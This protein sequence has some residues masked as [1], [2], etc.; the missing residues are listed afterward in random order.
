MPWRQ[1]G[2]S[3]LQTVAIYDDIGGTSGRFTHRRV[4][5]TRQTAKP[6]VTP[7]PAWGT[8][9]RW[10]CRTTIQRLRDNAHWLISHSPTPRTT[11]G[12]THVCMSRNQC[13]VKVY[14]KSYK[15][16]GYYCSHALS[17]SII[18]SSNMVIGL[19]YTPEY[20]L[21]RSGEKTT[22]QR[23]LQCRFS[24]SQEATAC[25]YE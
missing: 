22:N 18:P 2:A 19:R 5:A 24:P 4:P 20:V 23:I 3:R 21:S 6:L 12:M 15:N 9:F 7:C 16:N 13:Y 25:L 11:H 10:N 14:V 17:P 1:L 8:F